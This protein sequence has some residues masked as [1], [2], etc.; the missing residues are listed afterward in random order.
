MVL[1]ALLVDVALFSPVLLIQAF[2]PVTTNL[3]GLC[4][5][6]ILYLAEP[7]EANHAIK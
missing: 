7:S 3:L 2:N 1:L 6:A 4:L 5:C